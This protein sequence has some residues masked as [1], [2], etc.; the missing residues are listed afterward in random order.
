MSVPV[1]LQSPKFVHQ[2][3][4]QQCLQGMCNSYYPPHPV[5]A[6]RESYQEFQLLSGSFSN[7]SLLKRVLSPCTLPAFCEPF[8]S[9]P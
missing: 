7:K 6:Q 1:L 2:M 5:Q 8:P 9:V 3:Y 4:P